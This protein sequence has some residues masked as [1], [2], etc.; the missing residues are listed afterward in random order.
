MG[1]GSGVAGRPWRACGRAAGGRP[2]AVCA[3]AVRGRK[4]AA[5]G[6][7]VCKG[8]GAERG[9]V[10]HAAVL[11][12]RLGQAGGPVLELLQPA[13]QLRHLAASKGEGVH[14]AWLGRPNR[15]PP[16][17]LGLGWRHTPAEQRRVCQV[18]K[19]Q[20]SHGRGGRRRTASHRAAETAAAA[21][22]LASEGVAG[23]GG[24]WARRVGAGGVKSPPCAQIG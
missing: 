21:A 20:R 18:A 16:A 8:G 14:G 12:G 9:G 1:H 15:R 10:Q 17:Q 7:P 22:G 3:R 4:Q 6:T 23:G 13:V 11:F 19:Q 24:G 5:A 2:T